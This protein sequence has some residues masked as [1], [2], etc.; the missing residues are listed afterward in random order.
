MFFSLIF[1]ILHDFAPLND[2]HTYIPW[3][4]YI[5]YP[6]YSMWIFYEDDI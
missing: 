6:N 3:S 1:P 4:W 2:V 5:P